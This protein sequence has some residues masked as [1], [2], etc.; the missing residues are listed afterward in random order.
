MENIDVVVLDSFPC[1]FKCGQL[2]I[3]VRVQICEYDP[4]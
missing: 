1:Q 4:I 3:N 2:D